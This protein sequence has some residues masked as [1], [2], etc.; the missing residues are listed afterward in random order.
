MQSI[1]PALIAS[2]FIVA[3]TITWHLSKPN[4]Q[5]LNDAYIV[6]TNGQLEGA[7][8]LKSTSSTRLTAPDELRRLIS[9]SQYDTQVDGRLREDAN[10]KLIIETSIRDLF[11]YFFSALGEKT[12]EQIVQ[13]IELYIDSQLSAKAAIEAKALLKSFVAYNEALAGFT[14][15]EDTDLESLK[16]QALLDHYNNYHQLLADARLRYFGE[17]TSDAFFSSEQQYQNYNLARMELSLS[18]ISADAKQRQLEEIK[19][20]LPEAQQ[21][22]IRGHEEFNQLK[23]NEQSWQQ[24]NLSADEL[25][26]KRSQAYGSEAAERMSTLD[27]TRELWKNR[28]KGFFAEKDHI[29][30]S[31]LSG[32]DKQQLVS[33][34]KERQFSETERLRVAVLEEY[35]QK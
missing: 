8:N 30:A 34:L 16:G 6:A 31:N 35:R 28:L 22:I 4:E 10:G 13:N 3:A 26:S 23:V 11:D 18:T 9:P 2:T 25:Y 17:E 20:Q 21:S 5:G 7:N 32:P 14:L 19:H 1:K 15:D 24:E 29:I 12:P 33:E 27:Q